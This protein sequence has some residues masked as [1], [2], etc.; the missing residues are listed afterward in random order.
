M[1]VYT[2]HIGAYRECR[3]GPV[4][5]RGNRRCTHNRTHHLERYVMC[6]VC[7]AYVYMLAS[8]DHE[9]APTNSMRG[10]ESLLTDPS[11][12]EGAKGANKSM[13]TDW[14]SSQWS[15]LTSGEEWERLLRTYRDECK[16]VDG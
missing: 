7:D 5:P 12:R 10:F 9:E 6:I 4:R 8:F 11:R 16:K 1:P 2:I 3:S 15:D 14:L 13:Q